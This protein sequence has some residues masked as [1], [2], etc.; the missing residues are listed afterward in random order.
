LAICD[1]NADAIVVGLYPKAGEV[2]DLFE[3]QSS[4]NRRLPNI[5]NRGIS[6][7]KNAP[8]LTGGKWT[9]S[10]MQLY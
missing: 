6:C 7:Q 4:Q 2:I 1:L 3:D 5:R 8:L 10:A 9:M